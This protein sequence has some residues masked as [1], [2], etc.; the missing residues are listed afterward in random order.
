[1]RGPKEKDNVGQRRWHAAIMVGAA[2]ILLAWVLWLL[3]TAAS[4]FGVVRTYATCYDLNG[5]T[6]SGVWVGPRVAAH[7]FIAFRTRIRI[8]SRQAGPR[9]H[10]LYVIRDTG[11]ALSDGHIDLW[12]YKGDCQRYGVRRI[13]FKFGW[14]KPRRR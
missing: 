1:M 11:P 8:T 9:G 14:S 6:A 2:L 10:R 7:N 12:S 5:Q 4:A 3:S 13:T